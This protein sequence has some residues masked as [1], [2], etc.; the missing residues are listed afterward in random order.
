MR[1]VLIRHFQTL[2][3]LLGRYIGTTDED[4]IPEANQNVTINY[5]KVEKIYASPLKRCIQTASILYPKQDVT[6]HPDL[7]E[8]DF[9]RF[10]N[11]N[12]VELTGDVEYQRWIDSN[13]TIPF[14]E[15]ESNES[16]HKRCRSAFETIVGEC[17]QS[18]IGTVALVVHGGTIM[19]ILSAFDQQK[20]SFYDYQVKNGEGYEVYL[21]EKD[22][23]EG[24]HLL[25]VV[26]KLE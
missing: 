17:I 9:G 5:P 23:L 19:S 11:K 6:L 20:G 22:W 21:N 14:P 10:E 8:C 26:R 25:K 1:L 13:G 4:L 7:R 18:G 2:G 12:Y 15:G 3:N 16:F 24:R